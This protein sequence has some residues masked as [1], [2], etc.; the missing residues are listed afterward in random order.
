LAVPISVSGRKSAEL[1]LVTAEDVVL[2]AAGALGAPQAANEQYRD[3]R[4]D[5][6]CH[7]ASA[8]FE[9]LN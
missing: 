1:N 9:P 2:F 5:N 7:E 4:R 6:H 3:A 8:R